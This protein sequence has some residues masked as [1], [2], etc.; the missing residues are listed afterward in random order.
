MENLLGWFFLLIIFI[1]I[2]V[3]TIKYRYLRNLLL[4][5][6]LLRAT[7]AL[8]DYYDLIILPDSRNDASNFELKAI[9]FS[10]NYGLLIIFDLF[11][12]SSADSIISKII[13]IFYTIFGLSKLMAQSISVALGTASVYLVYY[14]CLMIWDSRSAKKAA[15]A[16]ALFPTL[17]LYSSL[18]LREVYIVFFLLV[19][20]IGIVKFIKKKNITSLL[21]ILA[22]FYILK[23]FHGP[24]AIGA[25]VFLFYLIL[26]LIKK[27]FNKLYYL[28]INL[29]SV[30]VIVTLS[31]PL[32]M[33]ST[34]HIEIYY[35]PSLFDFIAIIYKSNLGMVDIASYPSWLIID[36][37]YE[38]L[39]K[40]II[41]SFYFL[42]SPF[43]WDIKTP[44]HLIGLLD[45]TLYL[46]LTFYIIKN[47]HTIWTNPITR[48]IVL[49]LIAYIIVYGLGVGNFGTAIRH[50]SKF[51]VL[52]IILAAPKIHK[53]IFS[54][55]KKLYKR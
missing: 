10:K 21:Q 46:I 37:N 25:F 35:L 40:G 48:I 32:V 28:R 22:S 8:F 4:I 15:W 2:F 7:C 47:W 14:L 36:N 52:L 16:T 30:F 3:W 34:G 17:I 23:F 51:T 43:I 27:V 26:N 19:G 31:I 49:I 24:A 45:G 53:F 18:I 13:S 29:S 9:E 12:Y 39:T 20:L 1:F 42:Y 55:K 54:T 38:L 44:Y 11:K 6:F 33:L 50:R 5:A 41:K